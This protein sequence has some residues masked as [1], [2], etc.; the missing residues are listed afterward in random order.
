MPQ[1]A[2]TASNSRPALVVCGRRGA[3]AHERADRVPARCAAPLA[4]APPGRPG[5]SSPSACS[6]AHAIRH[7]SR[8]AASPPGSRTGQRWPGALAAADAADEQLAAPDGAVGA[9]PRAVVDRADGRA[10]P[11]RARPGRP[12]GA[13]GGAG[14][15]PARRRRAR[16]RRRSRG[17][18]G[19]GRARRSRARPRTA[20]RSARS[21]RGRSAASPSS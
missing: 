19:G 18:R 5:R 10:R 20:A 7:G 4:R 9:Q 14:P 21:P 12:R 3:A 2:A 8:T 1:S 6:Q 15:R 17:S 11:R 13:R 16:A